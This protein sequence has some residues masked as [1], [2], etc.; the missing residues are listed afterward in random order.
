MIA[1]LTKNNKQKQMETKDN[2]NTGI[3]NITIKPMITS[4]RFGTSVVRMKTST[5]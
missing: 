4:H 5:G 1:Q 2:D 3:S